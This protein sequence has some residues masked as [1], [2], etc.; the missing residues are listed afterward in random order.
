MDQIV[1]YAR[2][3]KLAPARFVLSDLCR[4]NIFWSKRLSL[5]QLTVCMAIEIR[6]SKCS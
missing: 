3:R 4:R 1:E 6:L 5:R 2:P